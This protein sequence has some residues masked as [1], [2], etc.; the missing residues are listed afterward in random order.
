M[1]IYLDLSTKSYK[2]KLKHERRVR[3]LNKQSKERFYKNVKRVRERSTKE[4]LENWI[5]KVKKDFIKM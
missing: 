4:E 3:K 2:H 5:N 1:D